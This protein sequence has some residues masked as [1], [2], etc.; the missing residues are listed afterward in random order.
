M[1]WNTTNNDRVAET[2]LD[3]RVFP[4]RDDEC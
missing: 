4:L 2:L 1:I 3:M